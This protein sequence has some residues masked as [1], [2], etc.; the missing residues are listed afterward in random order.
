MSDQ[1]DIVEINYVPDDEPKP[2]EKEKPKKAS[3]KKSTSSVKKLQKQIDE[4]GEIL[5]KVSKERD[6]WQDK[7]LRSLAEVDNFRKRIK[8]EKEEY[9][10]YVLADFI[11][12]LL[13]VY[14]NFERALKA[15][16]PEE[17]GKKSIVSGVEMI[18]RQLSELLKKNNVEEIDALGERF[19]PNI[20][21]ALSKEEC[22][23]I[24]EP[25]VLEVYQKGFTYKGKLLR[26]A[27]AKV[28]IPHKEEPV[29]ETE[30]NETSEDE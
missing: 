13:E 14:D 25:V 17:D 18:F 27:L 4:Q 5:V 8:K 24:E 20:H 10:K 30:E 15:G 19:D 7:Y 22:D 12:G 2:E 6:E 3:K 16:D 11:L 1:E 29:K 9:Q 26:P 23:N 21:Q 28:A